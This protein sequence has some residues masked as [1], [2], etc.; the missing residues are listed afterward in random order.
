[1]S[2]T[3]N[4]TD[5]SH[6]PKN[7]KHPPTNDKPNI[8]PTNARQLMA[9]HGL[10]PQKKLGQN[11]LIDN[12]VLDKIVAAAN[13]DDSELVIEI[14]PGLGALTN[15]LAEIAQKVCAIEIDTKL[16]ELLQ[17]NA[18][19]NVEIINKDILKTDLADIIA[20]NSKSGSAKLVA[21]LPYYITTPIIFGVLENNLPINTMVVMVQKEV[22]DRILAG[23]ST[24]AYGLLTLSIAY[25]G[26]ASLI[27]NVP[28]NCFFPRPDVHSA[29][30]KIDV[31]PHEH[32]NKDLFFAITKAAFSSRRKTLQNC[33]ASS[34]ALEIS[35]DDAAGLIKAAGLCKNIRGEALGFEQFTE[36]ARLMAQMGKDTVNG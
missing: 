13:L 15:R 33:L 1:M 16:A 2:G 30:I 10:Y 17:A 29:V 4:N 25:Y 19:P 3:Y 20:S 34:K 6:A 24:K 11:F 28:P 18:A 35:K 23:P 31:K 32:I 26:K 14:G 7:D 27:A 9:K 8:T 5:N 22:A 36:L 21:N 12:H